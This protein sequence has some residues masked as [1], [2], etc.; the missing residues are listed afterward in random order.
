MIG[1]WGQAKHG[2][3][4]Y[5][6]GDLVRLLDDGNY[7]YLGRRDHMVKVRGYRVE[8]GDI[9][10]ALMKHPAILEAA[11]IV[12]GI[13]IEVRLVAFIVCWSYAVPS[14]LEIKRH[15][16]ERLP[17]YMIIDEVYTIPALPYTRNGKVDRLAL[18][19]SE[20]TTVKRRNRDATR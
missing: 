20:I 9:E 2:D 16:A 18:L 5:A 12:A 4:P 15:Y 3:K 1:Y 19:H 6:T 17:R 7:L 8:P 10:A 13:G 11:V 14:L